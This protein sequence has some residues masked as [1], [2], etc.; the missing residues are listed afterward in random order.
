MKTISILLLTAAAAFPQGTAVAQ[1]TPGRAVYSSPTVT[2]ST[3]PPD[4]SGITDPFTQLASGCLLP[5]LKVTAKSTN[6]RVNGFYILVTATYQGTPFNFTALV[7]SKD[8]DGNF[9]AIVSVDPTSNEIKSVSATELT[10]GGI[11][12]AN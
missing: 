11:A 12:Y 10:T 4:C 1:R 3:D 7:F 6:P 9:S 8:A 5:K 2:Y